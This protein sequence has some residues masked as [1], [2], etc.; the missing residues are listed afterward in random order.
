[1]TGACTPGH[2]CLYDHW[3]FN[4]IGSAPILRLD[5]DVAHLEEYNFNDRASTLYNR[6]TDIVRIYPDWNFKGTPITLLPGESTSLNNGNA[7]ND[8]ASS[9]RWL[10]PGPSPRNPA[11]LC[12]A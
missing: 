7:G 3:D 1:M 2:P 12:G 9:V 11:R 8:S 10:R 6:T 5:G 4:A